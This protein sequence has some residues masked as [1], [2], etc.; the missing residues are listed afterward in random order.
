GWVWFYRQMP[1]RKV[2]LTKEVLTAKPA[3]RTEEVTLRTLASH[4][5]VAPG[6][7]FQLALNFQ[8]ADGWH[9]YGPKKGESYLPT[10]IEWKL[11]KGTALK[12][13]QWPKPLL[14]SSGESVQPT[15]EGTI[16]VLVTFIAPKNA[17][18]NSQ[19]KLAAKVNWQVC[20][21][22]LCKLGDAKL[23]TSIAVGAPSA[24]KSTP[25]STK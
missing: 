25:A 20:R 14:V 13:I 6:Q 1:Q 19:L 7:E 9:I 17:K 22:L 21:E 12:A 15:Y 11:P 23:E 3:T 24:R 5:S 10:T 4:T 8:I 16:T 2:N 18:A